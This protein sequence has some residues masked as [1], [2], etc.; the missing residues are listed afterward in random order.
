MILLAL[1]ACLDNDPIPGG[2]ASTFIALQSD[3]ADFEAWDA[4]SVDTGDTGHAAGDRVVYLNQPP[5]AGATA[6][7]IGTVLV[8]TIATATGEDIHAMAKRAADF[9]PDGAAGWEW[10]ELVRATDGTPV[11]KWRG[12][13]PPDGEAYGALPGS[14]GD[15]G[16]SVTGDC[17]VCH[18][19]ASANDFVHTVAL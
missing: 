19:A 11:I 13:V 18:G 10:F 1:L 12:D 3:F 6:F 4:R 2:G 7:P 14:E 9:N 5:P 17:N 16:D 8:K 15:T